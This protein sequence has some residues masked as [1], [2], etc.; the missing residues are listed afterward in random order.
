M[1]KSKKLVFAQIFNF[2]KTLLHLQSEAY[3]DQ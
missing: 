1:A 3:S 2:Y